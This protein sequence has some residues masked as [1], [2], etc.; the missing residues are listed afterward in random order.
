M[1]G[2]SLT[3]FLRERENTKNIMCFSVF[4]IGNSIEEAKLNAM[5]KASDENFECFRARFDCIESFEI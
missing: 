4:E 5:I 3:V 2:Y 1:S